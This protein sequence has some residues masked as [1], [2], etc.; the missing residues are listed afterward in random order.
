MWCSTSRYNNEFDLIYQNIILYLHRFNDKNITMKMKGIICLETEFELTGKSSRRA[1][2]TEPLLHFLSNTHGIPYIY[3]KV[4]TIEELKYYMT[5]FAK[6]KYANNYNIYYFSFHGDT[7][8]IQFESGESL[9]LDDLGKLAN[10]I[11][12]GKFVHFGS[13]RTMLGSLSAVEEFRLNTRAKF[14][15]GFTKSVPCDLCAIHDAAFIS[16]ILTCKQMPTIINHMDKYYGGL[17]KK[18]GFRFVM[19]K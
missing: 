8:L 11:F 7:H 1:L 10:G 14:V 4:A 9:D 17:Q 15:S 2:N 13:C 3:R 5:H 18:L 6:K 12:E 16:E 19:C